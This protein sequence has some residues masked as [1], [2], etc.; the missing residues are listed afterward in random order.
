MK[1]V[2]KV[3]LTIS[4]GQNGKIPEGSELRVRCDVDANPPAHI[5]RWYVNN[6]P[7]IGD[8]ADEMVRNNIISL[9]FVTMT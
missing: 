5:Y 4:S 8:Y 2:P 6:N 7:V 1:Y 3:N 9:I